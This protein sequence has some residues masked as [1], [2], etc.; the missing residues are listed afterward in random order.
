MVQCPWCWKSEILVMP[1]RLRDHVTC[2]S[3]D[4][5]RGVVLKDGEALPS[6]I[7]SL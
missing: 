7:E 6:I 4:L 2:G 5:E 1:V 3:G